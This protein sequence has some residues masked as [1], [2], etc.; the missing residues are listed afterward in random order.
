[1]DRAG[2]P[3]DLSPFIEIILEPQ[4]KR[5]DVSSES[6]LR[7]TADRE[8]STFARPQSL[9]W[10][11]VLRQIWFWILV[12]PG[13]VL[14]LTLWLWMLLTAGKETQMIWRVP[15]IWIP[16][17]YR[18]AN[19]E[20]AWQ[21]GDF[22][23]FYTNTAFVASLNVIAVLLSCSI[24]AYAFARIQFPGRNTLFLIVLSTMILP[25]QVTLIPLFMIFSALGWVNTF[26]PLVVPLFFGD[27]F[28]IFLLRQFFMTIPREL[29]DAALIDGCIHFSVF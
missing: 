9:Q 7:R 6:V 18:W 20:E 24:A 14:F 5:I 3:E 17:T 8:K 22:L 16:P 25:M 27:A 19:Y 21:K 23:I 11:T 29:D 4:L 15:L 2:L 10:R 28:S 13:A 12:L 26:K 1:M